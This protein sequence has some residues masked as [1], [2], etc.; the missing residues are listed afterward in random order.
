MNVAGAKNAMSTGTVNG[1]GAL[2]SAPASSVATGATADAE[3][4][5]DA[6]RTLLGDTGAALFAVSKGV[7][8]F[9]LFAGFSP[10]AIH[11]RGTLPRTTTA[12]SQGQSEREGFSV[13]CFGGGADV[14]RDDFGFL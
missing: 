2:A 4:T 7:V 3:G 1:T 14:E 6:E 5:G 12:P 11:A 9:G 10:S 8:F 13:L